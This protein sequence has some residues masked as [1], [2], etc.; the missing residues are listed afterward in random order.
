MAPACR[1]GSLGHMR[2]WS[3]TV[4]R[5]H[6]V[7]DGSEHRVEA[8]GRVRHR[9]V[10]FADGEPLA[11]RRRW[12]PRARLV[13]PVGE[14]RL[15]TNRVFLRRSGSRSL[16]AVEF[17]PESGSP[18][19]RRRDEIINRPIWFATR[20]LLIAV[21][22]VVLPIALVALVVR[23]L[24]MLRDAGVWLPQPPSIPFADFD[25]TDLGAPSW[26][27]D[28]LDSSDYVLPVVIALGIIWLE[29]RRRRHLLEII[30]Q[31]EGTDPQ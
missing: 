9:F 16:D 20:E 14:L 22:V 30:E 18:A 26:F 21:A 1:Y 28:L 25:L 11:V 12:L 31:R 23:L 10:W 13:A 3:P 15:T 6:G 7:V 5:W 24:G 29:L 17:E 4:Q 19:A 2:A 27:Q 8:T